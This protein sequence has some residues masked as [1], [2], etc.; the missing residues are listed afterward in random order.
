MIAVEREDVVFDSNNRPVLVSR[1]GGQTSYDGLGRA[2]CVALRME[3]EETEEAHQEDLARCRRL[4]DSSARSRCYESANARDHARR[5]DRP[6]PPLITWREA[7]T[8]A[9]L[10]VILYWIVSEGSRL[11]PPR[12]L[13]PIP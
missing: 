7:A 11:F 2:E 3:S 5:N 9:T 10:G 1:S 12:N 6:L 4:S 13:I 8:L